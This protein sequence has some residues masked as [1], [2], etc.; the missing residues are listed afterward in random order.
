M[1]PHWSMTS[2]LQDATHQRDQKSIIDKG[3]DAK[4]TP[5]VH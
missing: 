5:C 1:V 3:I 4:T 2:A